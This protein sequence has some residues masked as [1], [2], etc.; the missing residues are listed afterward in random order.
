MPCVMCKG[1]ATFKSTVFR[2]TSPMV[3][4]LCG[5]CA[6]KVRAD[7]RM[8]EIKAAIGHD[9]KMA[10]VDEFLGSVGL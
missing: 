4:K 7:E 6:D 10:A 1:T 2:G 5:D 3:V 9:A 8:R